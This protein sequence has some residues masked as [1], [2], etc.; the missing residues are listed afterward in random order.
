MNRPGYR[1]TTDTTL[2]ALAEVE[3]QEAYEA[4]DREQSERDKHSGDAGEFREAPPVGAYPLSAGEGTTCTVNGEDGTLV[5]QGDFLVCQPNKRRDGRTVD[6]RAA[7][8]AA[9]DAEMATAYLR[10]K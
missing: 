6:A 7:A 8:Y 5:R 9:Y 10:G 4:Y 2:R 1:F 3:R